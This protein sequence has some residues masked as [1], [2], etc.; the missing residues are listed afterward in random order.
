MAPL[1]PTTKTLML[2][3]FVLLSSFIE[4]LQV[5]AGKPLGVGEDVDLYDPSVPDREGL[6][7]VRLSTG[8]GCDEAGGPVH[9]RG[10]REARHL[11]E[12]GRELGHG[13]GAVH[14]LCRRRRER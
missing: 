12:A 7:G 10:P 4:H 6:D 9:E 8:S 2:S 11:R 5:E 3:S 14:L 13:A 1:A